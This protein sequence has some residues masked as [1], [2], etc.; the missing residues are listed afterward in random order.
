MF[1]GKHVNN[2]HSLSLAK[3]TG[4]GAQATSD[5]QARSME[6]S[7]ELPLQRLIAPSP[8]T[9]TLWTESA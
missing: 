2:R 4:K 3:L 1:A 8:S 7:I 5:D 6:Q 9:R